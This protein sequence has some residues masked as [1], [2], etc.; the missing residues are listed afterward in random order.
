MAAKLTKSNYQP[1]LLCLLSRYMN[2]INPRLVGDGNT[3]AYNTALPA[4][5][6]SLPD[7]EQ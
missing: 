3:Y 4:A 5:T 2:M 1:N 6:N 7:S